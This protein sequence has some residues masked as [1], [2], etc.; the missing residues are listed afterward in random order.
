MVRVDKYGRGSAVANGEGFVDLSSGDTFAAAE[1]QSS[2][3]KFSII[4]PVYNVAPY[5][6]ECLDSIL[7]QTF[8][9]PSSNP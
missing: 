3:V 2:S 8:V 4:I 5:L 9:D 6:R 1:V 7:A